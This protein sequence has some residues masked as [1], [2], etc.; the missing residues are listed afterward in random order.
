[1]GATSI[2]W[3]GVVIIFCSNKVQ[4]MLVLIGCSTLTGGG[5]IKWCFLCF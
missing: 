5:V 1:M 2:W 4:C 3:V